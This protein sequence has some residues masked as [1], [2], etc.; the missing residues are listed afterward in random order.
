MPLAMICMALIF[1]CLIGYWKS[2]SLLMVTVFAAIVGCLIYV[3]QFLASVRPWRSSP[4][5]PLAPPW[6]CA[7]L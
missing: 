4:A 1:I 2:E 7:D 3:P 6:A 5:L